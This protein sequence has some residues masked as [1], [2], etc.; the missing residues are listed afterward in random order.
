MQG[1]IGY[2]AYIPYHRLRRDLI[3][4][5]LGRGAAEGSRSVASYDEDTTTM[6]V[7]AS[8]Y[9]LS[10]LGDWVPRR[11]WFSTTQPAYVD[12][13]NATV[14]HSAL[15][16]SESVHAADFLGSVRS[17]TS[18]LLAAVDSS[19]P[20]LVALSDTRS[21]LPG[22]SDERSGGDAAA[23]FAFD[24]GTDAFPIV[25]EIIGEGYATGEA[26]ERW[27]AP[28]ETTSHV[29]EDRFGEEVLAPSA[30]SAFEESLKSA[31]LDR[32]DVKHL[33][34]AGLNAR[35]CR[36]FA[37]VSHIDQTRVTNNRSEVLG[38]AGAAQA[39]VL[40]ADVLDT[41]TPDEIIA[42]VVLGDGALSLVLRTTQALRSHRS[43]QTVNDQISSTSDK[44]D[45][46]TYLQWRHFLHTEPPRRPEPQPVAAPPAHRN[47]QFKLGFVG[48]R[49]DACD[50]LHLPPRHRC[51]ACGSTRMS[52]QPMAGERGSL[53]HLII[54]HLAHTPSPPLVAG[55]I[56]FDAGGRYRCEVTDI[57]LNTLAVG[58]PVELTFRRLATADGVHNYF[59]KARPARRLQGGVKWPAM[60]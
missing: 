14:V 33:I 32:A 15:G 4:Q 52:A 27:R 5:F 60:A 43:S 24:S 8:R 47:A 12:K 51:S 11:L 2:S 48:S 16:L 56:D 46:A 36:S 22:G 1:I 58:V 7:E 18:T 50:A 29:W 45:Y 57:D 38:N 30:V 10:D 55:A 25:A 20:T 35:A 6:A 42:V 37:S 40:L 31:G 59:W 9:L 54:D 41:A 3:R 21:G 19:T 34:V 26:L 13:T 49:C 53:S 23:A 28:G 17:G 44:L 39:G